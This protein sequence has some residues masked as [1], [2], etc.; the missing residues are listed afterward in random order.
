MFREING[1]LFAGATI[2]KKWKSAGAAK[3]QNESQRTMKNM[4]TNTDKSIPEEETKTEGRDGRGNK[5]QEMP[6]D[7]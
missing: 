5:K 7:L 4:S 1:T 3:V 2:G 6:S